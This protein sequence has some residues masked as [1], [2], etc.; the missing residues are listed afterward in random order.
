MIQSVIVNNQSESRGGGIEAVIGGPGV[1]LV[2]S[3]VCDNVIDEIAGPVFVDDASEVCQ[4]GSDL[5][6]DGQTNGADL[7]LLLAS[8]GSCDGFCLADIDGDGEVT[9]SDL[10]LILAGWG[11]CP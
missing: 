5:T 9:G 8:F 7:G 11:L 3:L 6:G 10:G 4:C 2:G 1:Q